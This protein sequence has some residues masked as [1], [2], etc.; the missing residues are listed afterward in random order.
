MKKGDIVLI[1][2]P[3]SDFSNG[4]TRPYLVMQIF[5]NDAI[6]CPLTTQ[7]HKKSIPLNECDII[8]GKIAPNS[9][10]KY[11]KIT[12]IEKTKVL[13]TIA[14]LSNKKFKNISKVF[15]EFLDL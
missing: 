8:K 14:R 1:W 9:Q 15:Q 4:K 5:E 6:L 11:W 7:P 3:F 10:L 2:F 12:T 13:K